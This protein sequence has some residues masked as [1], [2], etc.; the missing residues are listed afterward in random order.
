M[1]TL[2]TVAM[3]VGYITMAVAALAVVG[4]VVAIILLGLYRS[5]G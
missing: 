5:T 3:V 4:G 1:D 2:N